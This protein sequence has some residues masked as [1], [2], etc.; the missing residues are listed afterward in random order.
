M[1]TL[2]HDLFDEPDPVKDL[3]VDYTHGIPDIPERPG[4]KGR[5]EETDE[6]EG[7][8]QDHRQPKKY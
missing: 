2:D 6:G 3:S 8:S 7:C 5:A 1:G 4:S